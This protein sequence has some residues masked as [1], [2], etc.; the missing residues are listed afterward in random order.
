MIVVYRPGGNIR[1]AIVVLKPIDSGEDQTIPNRY[2]IPEAEVLRED[3]AGGQLLI[4]PRGEVLP[5][6]SPLLSQPEPEETNVLEI[7]AAKPAEPKAPVFE[8]VD[9]ISFGAE[10]TNVD[11]TPKT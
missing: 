9:I 5:K 10:K 7:T 2:N 8:H 3:G 4:K 6:D 1:D 11:E